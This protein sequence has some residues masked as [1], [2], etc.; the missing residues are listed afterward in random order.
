[1]N[2]NVGSKIQS[3]K[4]HKFNFKTFNSEIL[5]QYQVFKNPM[6]NFV[7]LNPLHHEEAFD[8]VLFVELD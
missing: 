3:Y 7:L 6:T 5:K 8:G 2:M 4:R 1:M